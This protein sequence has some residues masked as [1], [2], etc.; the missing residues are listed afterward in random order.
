MINGFGSVFVRVYYQ[1][2]EL[3]HPIDKF[4]YTYDEQEPDECVFTVRSMDWSLPDLPEFQL[5]VE[6]RVTW[7]YIG[8]QT[9]SRKVYIQDL[10]PSFEKDGLFFEIT[11]TDK[12]IELR[13][14]NSKKLHKKG[15]V[16]GLASAL[17]KK[18]GIETYIEYGPNNTASFQGFLNSLPQ[19]PKPKKNTRRGSG[20]IF[21]SAVGS[22]LGFPN[23][24]QEFK[25]DAQ[26]VQFDLQET[27]GF[28]QGLSP[29]RL[30]LSNYDEFVER[31][32]GSR[33]V[34]KMPS[35][36]FFASNPYFTEMYLKSL[37]AKEQEGSDQTP[38]AGKTDHAVLREKL[39]GFDNEPYVLDSRDDELTI[40]KRNFNQ[41]PFRKY[42]YQGEDGFLL[43]FNPV[44]KSRSRSSNNNA[45]QYSGWDPINKTF[46]SNRADAST[47]AT[48]DSLSNYLTGDLDKIYVPQIFMGRSLGTPTPSDATQTVK[49]L[50]IQ[51]FEGQSKEDFV[52]SVIGGRATSQIAQG[53]RDNAELTMNPAN[54]L[55][56]G[57]P[58]LEVGQVI[59]FENVSKKFSGNYYSIK[60]IHTIDAGV[61][62]LVNLELTRQGVNV[63]GLPSSI[64]AK[65]AKKRINK[66]LGVSNEDIR[67][68]VK[69]ERNKR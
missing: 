9:K 3:T 15:D 68:K 27:T 37:K 32:E 67:K 8:G 16:I 48:E 19:K 59:T 25:R 38:Q 51:R 21:E 50:M 14:S 2:K 36:E 4:K 63:K 30:L 17:G 24:D 62:Y 23:Q 5:K 31:V 7:G 41:T 13:K 49:S 11:C 58:N 34:G 26:K 55:V 1:D 64:S 20:N 18:H 43:T 10:K 22:L 56:V 60:S 61:P 66:Q 47:S 53:I 65:D 39:N 28:A 69:N 29:A 52:K 35:Q 45:V 54:A 57:D 42:T 46:K 6:L 44:T 33:K 12:S 40:R